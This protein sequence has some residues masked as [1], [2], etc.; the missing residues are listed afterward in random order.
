MVQLNLS[1]SLDSFWKKK[2]AP[3]WRVKRVWIAKN[4][5]FRIASANSF[6]IFSQ[7]S[8]EPFSTSEKGLRWSKQIDRRT[9]RPSKV[10]HNKFSILILIFV[11]FLIFYRKIFS[12]NRGPDY[13]RRSDSVLTRLKGNLFINTTRLLQKFSC[14]KEI[15]KLVGWKR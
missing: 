2:S 13:M 8:D 3:R 14:K 1:C 12:I 11:T 4:E 6:I 10:G 15:E 9:Y 5:Y 7:N